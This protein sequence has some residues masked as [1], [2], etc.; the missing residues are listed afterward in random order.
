MFGIGNSL[1]NTGSKFHRGQPIL[2]REVNE[3]RRVVDVKPVTVVEDSDDQIAL[4]LPLDTPSKKPVLHNHTPGAPRRWTEGNWSLQDSFWRVAERLILIKPD[5]LRA[6]WVGWSRER[7][8]EGWY[9]NMQSKLVRTRLGF[10]IRDHHLNIL[11][12]PDR[13]WRWKD[14]SELDLCVE[15]GRMDPV[16]AEDTRAEGLRAIAEIECNEGP[17]SQSWEDWHPDPTLSHPQ[18]TPDWNDLSMY[19]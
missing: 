2:Y 1:C 17:F 15:D 19:S 3:H 5:Q 7:V 14:A 6:T 18:L 4:W 11:V 8:F 12:E 10:D 9:V 16:Q 13:E